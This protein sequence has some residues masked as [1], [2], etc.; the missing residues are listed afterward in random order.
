MCYKDKTFCK[1]NECAKW[2][3]CHRS[4]TPKITSD[5]IKWWG[6]KDALIS[7]FTNKPDC[8]EEKL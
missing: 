7:I 1:F 6:S 3:N 2:S 8:Y 5:A 4:L